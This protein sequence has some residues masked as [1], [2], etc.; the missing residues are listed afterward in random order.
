MAEFNLEN[1][2]ITMSPEKLYAFGANLL[3]KNNYKSQCIGV[4]FIWMAAN[5]DNSN[6]QLQLS[7]L[8]EA[9]E[10]IDKDA[11]EAAA[12]LTK[13]ADQGNAEAQLQVAFNYLIGKEGRKDKKLAFE[14]VRKAADQGNAEA[15]FAVGYSYMTGYW[16]EQ[17]DQ[18]A[19]A[20]LKKAADQG[21]KEA[22]GQLSKINLDKGKN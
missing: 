16:V 12:W 4:S 19:A 7:Y 9:G 8:Y 3:S 21:H 1:E 11:Q 20:W 13:A 22:L 15:Q 2:M 14:W 5:L 18:K 17:D 6:A 10:I